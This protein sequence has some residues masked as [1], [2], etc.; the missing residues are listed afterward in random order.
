MT[1]FLNHSQ[2][3]CAELVF[4]DGHGRLELR[5]RSERLLLVAAAPDA[6]RLIQTRRDSHALS[7]LLCT[8]TLSEPVDSTLEETADA[9]WFGTGILRI[10]IS[11]TNLAMAWHDAAGRLL[12]RE[13]QRGGRR[14]EETDVLVNRVGPET[15]FRSEPSPDGVKIIAEGLESVIDR[16]A[17]HTSL[18]LELQPDERIFGLGS[19]EDGCFDYRGHA[20][21]LYH[22]NT[23]V[24]IPMLLSP[25][26]WGLLVD[27]ASF[28]QFDDTAAGLRLDCD[29]EDAMDFWF[30]LGP[31]FDRIVE[32]FRTLTGA[33]A[34]LPKWAFG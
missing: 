24:P 2:P 5:S 16:R 30:L 1:A 28:I 25:R 4:H 17:C 18:L 20:Q 12:V 7:P 11:R 29:C 8:G 26:G 19:H 10:R 23:K 6:V 13:P 9:W 34:P 3:M 15:R 22:H 33:V 21:E 32:R 14:L 27:S 31:A